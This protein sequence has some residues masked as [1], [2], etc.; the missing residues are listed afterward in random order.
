MNIAYMWSHFLILL[1]AGSSSSL[2][3]SW[4]FLPPP[5]PPA[6]PPSRAPPSRAVSPAFSPSRRLLLSSPLALLPL[7]SPR[8][9]A[10][11]SVALDLPPPPG[12]LL[13]DFRKATAKLVGLLEIAVGM[14]GED[15]K[16]SDEDIKGFVRD[17]LFP[18]LKDWAKDYGYQPGVLKVR[19][20]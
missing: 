18:A 10:S 17:E 12:A 2:V 11:A 20:R 8:R 15:G 4:F 6:P 16:A 19:A 7:A 9:P 14:L 5:P 1:V 3:E 13:E